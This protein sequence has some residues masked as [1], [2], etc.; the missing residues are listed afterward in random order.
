MQAHSSRQFVG[1][2]TSRKPGFTL[3]ELLV[4][5]MIVGILLALLLPGTRSARGAAR[6]SQCKVNLKQL[7]LALHNYHDTYGT[8]PPQKTVD[9]AGTDLQS[10]RTA[11]LP[12]LDQQTLYDEADST[13]PWDAP[14][15]QQLRETSVPVYHCPSLTSNTSPQDTTYLGLTGPTAAFPPSG[16]RSV[17]EM[18]AGTANVAMVHELTEDQRVL[19]M[20]PRDV[21]A[22]ELL[23]MQS[24]PTWPHEGGSHVL[25]ADGHVDFI[26]GEVDIES[27]KAMISITNGQD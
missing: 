19:W 1:V 15:N 26:S 11:L 16:C 5:V 9:A 18:T 17:S 4:V 8:F 21:A 27:R 25:F 7:G 22:S 20:M 10:W 23:E 24:S 12:Y 3:I 14:A 6:R 2:G 13:L